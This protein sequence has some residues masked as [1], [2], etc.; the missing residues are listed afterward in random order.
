MGSASFNFP[1]IRRVWLLIAAGLA[2]IVAIETS[3]TFAQW[4]I[5]V[6]GLVFVAITATVA[7]FRR[8]ALARITASEAR[9]KLQLRRMPIVCVTIDRERN[10]TSWNPAAERV[11]GWTTAEI[12]G[13]P[14]STLVPVILVPELNGVIESVLA[15]D[16]IE[17]RLGAN[18][19]KESRNITCSWAHTPLVENGEITGM[20]SMAQDVTEEQETERA[21][22][23]S[24]RTHQ[25]LLDALPHHI[26]SV[27]LEDRYLALNASACQ[28]FGL[29]EAEIVGRTPEE[30]GIAPELARR[31]R[32]VNAQTRE[33][34]TLQAFDLTCPGPEP[35][36]EHVITGPL[37]DHRGEIVG[38]TGISI[39][40]TE[41]KRAEQAQRLLDDQI[42]HFSK[43][44]AL[45]TLAGGVAHDFNNILSVI[46]AHATL[47][48]RCC[49][50]GEARRSTA[51]IK[52]AVGRGAAI[53]RQILT[54]ARHAEIRAGSVDVADLLSELHELVAETFP[55][56]VRI[57]LAADPDLPP[58]AGDAG[59]LHQALLNLCINGRDAMPEGGLLAIDARLAN[60]GTVVISISDDGVGMDEQTR[61]RIF[62]PFFSTKEKGKG[63]GLGLAMVYGIVRAH[64]A[65]MDV[66]SE[67][68]CGTS[69]RLY[70]PVSVGASPAIEAFRGVVAAHGERLLVIE[71]EPEILSGLEMQLTDAGY[72]VQTASN[73]ADA[74]ERFREI[75][76]LVLMDLGMPRMGAVE[77]IDALRVVAPETPIVAMTG[78]V[79]P[80]VHAAV[81]LAGVK[82][83][84]QKPFEHRELLGIVSE[85]LI[86][87]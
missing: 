79:D 59:Q 82:Q 51:S 41:K 1:P 52:K 11:F 46:L 16:V 76:D 54:F 10:I 56:T 77:L 44:E 48:D 15:G 50:H 75:P 13:R 61:R 33:T 7:E 81:R 70:F 31:W 21:L 78:Y 43:M 66:E 71:D 27:D 18:V 6:V 62:E 17:H 14:A 38:V 9:L 65:Q 26:F 29:S 22:Q 5:L 63:T 12:T 73:G 42:A 30:V 68:G 69:F 57:E 64:G 25:E 2:T 55:R 47:L 19:T 83:I 58:I 34:G 74:M 37:R 3:S 32:D 60:A 24:R 53:S 86:Q 35:R 8:A 67:L 80:E 85:A 20:L 45:G 28:W 4:H 40:V 84:L 49:A 23:E 36:Y 72:L 87:A 39:D